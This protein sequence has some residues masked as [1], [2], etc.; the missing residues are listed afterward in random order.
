MQTYAGMYRV[1]EGAYGFTRRQ[2]WVKHFDNE[3]KRKMP[4]YQEVFRCLRNG[5]LD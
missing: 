4:S 5:K 1:R 3:N 2:S